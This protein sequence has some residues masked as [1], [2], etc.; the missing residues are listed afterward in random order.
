[1]EDPVLR[2]GALCFRS[3]AAGNA[4]LRFREPYLLYPVMKV[5]PVIDL[6]K[7]EPVR[8]SPQNLWSIRTTFISYDAIVVRQYALPFF[9]RWEAW[10]S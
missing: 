6:A 8:R 2:H 3:F 4:Y 1:M 5:Y 7:G 10:K 9:F